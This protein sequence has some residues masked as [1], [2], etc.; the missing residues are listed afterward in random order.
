MSQGAFLYPTSQ[1]LNRNTSEKEAAADQEWEEFT[2]DLALCLTGLSEN[3]FLVLSSQPVHYYV[4]FAAQGQLG[5]RAE[6]M[7]NTFAK[8]AAMLSTDA[9]AA[10]VQL[11]WKSPRRRPGGS[12]NF[13]VD[14]SNPVDFGLLAELV[15]ETLRRVYHTFQ[16]GQLQYNAFTR[17][18]T[19]IRLPALGL[20]CEGG[21]LPRTVAAAAD[22]D[23]IEVRT[24]AEPGLDAGR[25]GSARC[26]TRAYRQE[27]PA[28]NRI[29]TG[30]LSCNGAVE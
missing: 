4:Q 17:T 22:G 16:P 1:R 12:P 25:D 27:R 3:E 30:R 8:P 26:G 14:L 15:V 29:R 28:E 21:E 24:D 20:K 23:P 5:M 10:M 2:C 9:C 19:Q 18:G 11:G 6:A 13:F 7:S